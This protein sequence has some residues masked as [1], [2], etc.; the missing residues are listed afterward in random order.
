[1]PY[2]QLIIFSAREALL[3]I[4]ISGGFNNVRRQR[5]VETYRTLI[6]KRTASSGKRK[7]PVSSNMRAVGSPVAPSGLMTASGLLPVLAN[8][9]N[10]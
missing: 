7:M 8:I 10:M 3:L 9:R 2:W 5:R 6:V 1:M 4:I